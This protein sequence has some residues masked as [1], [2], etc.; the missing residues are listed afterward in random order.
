MRIRG[1]KLWFLIILVGAALTWFVSG[2]LGVEQRLISL[3]DQPGVRTAFLDRDSAR[4]DAMVTLVSFGVLGPIAA[5][6]LWIIVVLLAK[7][8]ET[9]LVSVRLPAWLSTP[10][11]GIG[12]I[13]GCYV[14]SESWLSESLY[15]VGLV[16]R[17]YFIY[18]Y[19]AVP[20]FQ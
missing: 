3:A 12:L 11:T 9:L 5:A 16:A 8:V 7:G 19:G 14:T 15:A 17:A 10:L 13:I 6:F 20:T 18:S 1:Y 4:S 2:M